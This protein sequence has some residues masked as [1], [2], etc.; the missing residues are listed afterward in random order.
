MSGEEL[1]EQLEAEDEKGTEGTEDEKVVEQR[2]EDSYKKEVESLR[3]EAA[4]HRV[5]KQKAKEELKEFEA[6]KNSQKSELE[7]AEDRLKELESEL[8]VERRTRLQTDAAK[9]ADLDLDLADR[10]RGDSFDE[11]VEDAK[12]LASKYPKSKSGSP[13][14]SGAGERGK[15]VGSEQGTDWLKDMWLDS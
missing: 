3:R 6:W 5:E 12:A 1:V 15:P 13:G 4:K 9:E 8:Q 7:R 11:M 14:R 2:S 10:I